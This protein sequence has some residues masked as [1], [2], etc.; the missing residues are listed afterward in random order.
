M[1]GFGNKKVRIL[2]ISAFKIRVDFNQLKYNGRLKSTLHTEYTGVGTAILTSL[3]SM[4]NKL[5]CHP[6]DEEYV[7]NFYKKN[8]FVKQ[9]D[10]LNYYI[11]SK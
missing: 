10:N 7:I 11:Y 6:S 4:Y 8:G 2:V 3:K 5:S 9:P 1:F